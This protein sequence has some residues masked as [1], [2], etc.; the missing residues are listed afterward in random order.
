[1]G[2][3]P[4]MMVVSSI[5]FQDSKATDLFNSNVSA[6]GCDVVGECWKPYPPRNASATNSTSASNSSTP[7]NS[8][9]TGRK[10]LGGTRFRPT[11]LHLNTTT[12]P[13][14][15]TERVT[16]TDTR[17]GVKWWGFAI[18]YWALPEK[19]D[20]K[21]SMMPLR[22]LLYCICLRSFWACMVVL[23][24]KGSQTPWDRNGLL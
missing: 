3:Q 23:E 10:L 9:T 8:T 7:G 12:P 16:A 15:N 1:M 24:G 14:N 21:V 19:A 18:S 2:N 22:C 17:R 11:S 5:Y 6:V 20:G 4:V 13:T